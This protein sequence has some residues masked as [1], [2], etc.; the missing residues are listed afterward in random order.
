MIKK[1]GI[2]LLSVYLVTGCSKPQTVTIC[3]GDFNGFETQSTF[4]AAGDKVYAVETSASI[5]FEKFKERFNLSST[6]DEDI[7]KYL[8]E[9]FN[10]DDNR[11][12]RGVSR[13]ITPGDGNFKVDTNIDLKTAKMSDLHKM[14]ILQFGYDS[15][16]ERNLKLDDTIAKTKEIGFECTDTTDATE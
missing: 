1:I 9:S 2:L 6:T 13:T 7:V 12:I 14:S 16:N 4:K 3:K 8:N 10:L 11:A 5:T 15:T